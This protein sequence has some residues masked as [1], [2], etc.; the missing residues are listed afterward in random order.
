MRKA[1]QIASDYVL[2][3]WSE[4]VNRASTRLSASS[5]ASV[6]LLS[7]A[8]A[9]R[10]LL[11]R[12]AVLVLKWTPLVIKPNVSWFLTSFLIL[13]NIYKGEVRN[14]LATRDYFS[15]RSDRPGSPGLL[16]TSKTKTTK[17]AKA[18]QRPVVL[19]KQDSCD[20]VLNV[21]V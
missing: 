13:K 14:H 2:E 10:V 1:G 6:L 16:R 15:R 8:L 20:L 7:R 3:L 11:L 17:T 12:V 4:S 21:N 18:Q 5:F 19:Q 9:F